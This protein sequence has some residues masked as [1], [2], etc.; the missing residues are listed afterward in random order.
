MP[1]HVASFDAPLPFPDGSFSAIYSGDVVEH[2]YD[3]RSM[4]S[5]LAR[6]LE[7]GGLL[8]MS[9][10]YHGLLKNV[11]LSVFAFDRHFD[12]EGPHVRFFSER[13]LRNLLSGAGLTVERFEHF[14]RRWPLWANMAAVARR[15]R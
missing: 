10:P 13:T 5:E 14:G 11:V 12:P 3:V 2:V 7:P 15:P 9:T 6:V 8:F 1:L 4:A